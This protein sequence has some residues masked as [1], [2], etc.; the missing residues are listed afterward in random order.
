ML[1]REDLVV[2]LDMVTMLD[3]VAILDM[4]DWILVIM[5]TVG[6]LG[7]ICMVHI[8]GNSCNDEI[9]D[10][11]EDYETVRM[12]IKLLRMMKLLRMRGKFAC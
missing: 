7:I 9:D 3:M 5:I 8:D 4:V 2:M 11:V 1:D 10:T 12:N 6:R